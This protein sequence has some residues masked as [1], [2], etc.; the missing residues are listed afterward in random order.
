MNALKR[1]PMKYPR[2]GHSVCAIGTRWLFVSGSRVKEKDAEKK[3]EMFNMNMN[4]WYDVADLNVGRHYHSSC[5]MGDNVVYVFCGIDG[6]EKYL[7]LIEKYDSNKPEKWE[8]I[9]PSQRLPVRQGCGV[10]VLSC[11]EIMIFGGYSA[12]YLKDAYIFNSEKNEITP[13][14]RQPIQEIFCYQ[15]PSMY[16]SAS[17]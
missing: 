13:L 4:K 5:S 2:A 15:M 12:R 16:D 14:P 10:A 9:E 11:D 1:S 6:N 17:Q 3:C 7:N 8:L